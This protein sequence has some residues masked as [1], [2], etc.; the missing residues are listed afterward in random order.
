MSDDSEPVDL[1]TEQPE[2]RWVTVQEASRLAKVSVQ[3]IRRYYAG[4]DP[5]VPSRLEM[6]PY[7]EQRVMP[8]GAVLA[9]AERGRQPGWSPEPEEEPSADL[10]VLR[11][12]VQAM[13]ELANRLQETE[14]R[15]S[16]AETESEFLRQQ[17]AEQRERLAEERQ[18]REEAEATARL[19]TEKPEAVTSTYSAD[20]PRRWWQR[21]A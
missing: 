6:G 20:R 1:R 2:E 4:D 13:H 9:R 17:L 11:E 3:T 8:L 12:A 15:A 21:R 19:A 14:G 16:K 10:P 18:R 7:G 5:D